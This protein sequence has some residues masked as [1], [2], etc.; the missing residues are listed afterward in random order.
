MHAPS[1]FDAEVVSALGRL[2]RDGLLTPTQVRARLE[3]LVDAPVERHPL[4]PAVLGAWA[5][6]R[7]L[8]LVDALYVELVEQLDA[9][10]VTTD[11]R[12]AAT[13]RNAELV[14]P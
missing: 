9:T 14:G 5:R 6:R 1:H 3:A 12:L 10:L 11:Q 13:A 8:R 2:H 4:P 7:K